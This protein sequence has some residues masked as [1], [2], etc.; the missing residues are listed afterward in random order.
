MDLNTA[1]I[2]DSFSSSSSSE[3]VQQNYSDSSYSSEGSNKHLITAQSKPSVG[4]KIPIAKCK[5]VLSKWAKKLKSFPK[6]GAAVKEAHIVIS[7]RVISP[8]FFYSSS[9]NENKRNSED[10]RSGYSSDS[11]S[12]RCRAEIRR[13]RR[14]VNFNSEQF[15]FVGDIFYCYL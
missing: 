6:A 12:Y 2:E 7:E 8:E 9:N 11:D 3:S 5:T 10:S 15:A 13:R 14:H 4:K 1:Y